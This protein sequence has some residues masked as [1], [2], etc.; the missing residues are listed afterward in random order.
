MFK[1]RPSRHLLVA[2]LKPEQKAWE[3]GIE[4]TGGCL[5][6]VKEHF[7]HVLS[8]SLVWDRSEGPDAGT[9]GLI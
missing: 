7:L 3:Q 1:V 2:S 5:K 9:L 8:F 4:R 6:F